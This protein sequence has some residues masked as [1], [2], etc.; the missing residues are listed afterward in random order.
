MLE[1]IV[2]KKAHMP[3]LDDM[4]GLVDSEM[5][6][7]ALKVIES[8]LGKMAHM[9]AYE[10][11]FHAKRI[12]ET[13]GHA[14]ITILVADMGMKLGEE[15]IMNAAKLYYA[16]FVERRELTSRGLRRRVS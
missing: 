13:M 7:K 6:S 8:M 14:I 2:K 4:K 5:A 10:V 15:S 11:E 1:A 16:K 3:L 12:L 9:T